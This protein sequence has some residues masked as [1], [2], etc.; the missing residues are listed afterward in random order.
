MF[1]T[2]EQVTKQQ[3]VPTSKFLTRDAE[4]NWLWFQEEIS[5]LFVSPEQ[6]TEIKIVPATN[7]SFNIYTRLDLKDRFEY[8]FVENC[9]TLTSAKKT[10]EDFIK[11]I[12]NIQKKKQKNSKKKETEPESISALN[13]LVETLKK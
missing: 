7:G 11:M 10:S 9:K 13:K 5:Y 4:T 3:S 2:K 6:V 8:K 12:K 1:P